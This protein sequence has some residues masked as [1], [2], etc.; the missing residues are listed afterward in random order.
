MPG[1][2]GMGMGKKSRGRQAPQRP[3][4]KKSKSKNP[5]KAA[6]EQAEAAKRAAEQAA[7]V[8]QAIAGVAPGDPVAH[9]RL[10]KH[11]EHRQGDPLAALRALDANGG[12]DLNLTVLIEGSEE[13][14]GEGLSQLI[15]DRPE[16]FAADA[17]LIADAGNAAVGQPTLTTSLRGSAQVKVSGRPLTSRLSAAEMTIVRRPVCERQI[18]PMAAGVSGGAVVSA[19]PGSGRV[20][21]SPSDGASYQLPSAAGSAKRSIA[22]SRIAAAAAAQSDSSATDPPVRCSSASSPV[23]RAA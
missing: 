23:T 8:W 18:R 6:R 15:K 20:V 19:G 16:L 11:Y 12:T 10:A 14:G 22:A 1:G 13:R 17:I 21:R 4:G 7:R 9:E 2:P 5:A 3:Q